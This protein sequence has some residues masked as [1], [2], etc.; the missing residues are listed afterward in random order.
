VSRIRKVNLA[1]GFNAID[2]PWSPVIAAELNGQFIKLAKFE[3]SFQWHHHEHEDEGFLVIK[4]RLEMGFRD[5]TVTLDEGELIVVPRGIEH[6]PASRNGAWVL[7][8]EPK[9][10]RNTGEE[11][12]DRTVDDL[13]WTQ[14]ES[15]D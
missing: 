3:G 13:P 6:R 15:L 8:F 7:L 1:D 4:G 9:T 14:A 11:V 5:R 2:E 10:T 12:N